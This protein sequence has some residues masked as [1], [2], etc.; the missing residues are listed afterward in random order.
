MHPDQLLASGGGHRPR[1][2]E[3]DHGCSALSGELQH[4][5]GQSMLAGVRHDALDHV[6]L[7]LGQ[8]LP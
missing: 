1:F 4:L 6:A 2:D 5:H 8:Q 3:S 7:A